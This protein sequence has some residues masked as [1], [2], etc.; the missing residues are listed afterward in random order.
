M[1][2]LNT[3]LNHRTL[4][5]A[6]LLLCALSL[7]FSALAQDLAPTSRFQLGPT[8]NSFSSLAPG[9]IGVAATPTQLL[10]S[11]NG[12]TTVD[13]ISVNGGVSTFATLPSPG[14]L[15]SGI[16]ESYLA[17]S[18]GLGG[19]PTGYV[20][21]TQG[22]RIYQTPPTGGT[23]TL[24]TTL[25]AVPS[26]NSHSGITFDSVGTFGNAMIVSVFLGGH[27]KPAN[28]GHLKTGQ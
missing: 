16:C 21:V 13:M 26:D 7:S 24:F 5:T 28:S 22:N 9:P 20:Y 19:F 3:K 27:P 17:I 25:P 6:G 15:A 4:Q 14:A 2:L 10:T 18:P 23:V 1:P 8:I 12:C 11:L